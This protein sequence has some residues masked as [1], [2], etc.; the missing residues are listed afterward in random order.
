LRKIVD[1]VE[2]RTGRQFPFR[3]GS[4]L[5]ST[6]DAD[7]RDFGPARIMAEMGKVQAKYPDIGQLVL[8]A[9]RALHPIQSVASVKPLT[10]E[11]RRMA[12][13]HAAVAA[14]LARSRAERGAAA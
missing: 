1:Y 7:V 2:K 5:W 4:A 6:L 12:D 14:D 13:A 9:S 11:Q 3:A 8:S 10:A